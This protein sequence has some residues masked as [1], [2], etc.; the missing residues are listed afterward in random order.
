MKKYKE[1]HLLSVKH[2]IYHHVGISDGNG[3]VYEN[4]RERGGS[5]LVIDHIFSSGKPISDHGIIGSLSANTILER[6]KTLITDQKP[7]KL[8]N[9]NC[10]H[11]NDRYK[12]NI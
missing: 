12:V 11:F 4:S 8:F 10:E 2:G 6:A 7:Y 3:N 9:N 1:G 5:G